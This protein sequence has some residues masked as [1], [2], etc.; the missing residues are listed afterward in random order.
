MY[1]SLSTTSCHLMDN[2]FYSICIYYE[3]LLFCNF[4]RR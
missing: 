1:P 2:F 4:F 3:F